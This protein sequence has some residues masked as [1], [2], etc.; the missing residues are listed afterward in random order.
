[1]PKSEA[2][3]RRSQSSVRRAV[4]EYTEQVKAAA[5]AGE[6]VLCW[7]CNQPISFDV[8]D[9]YAGDH[10]EPDHVF[11]VATHPELAD[12]P[13]NLRPAHR[14]CNRARGTDMEAT[15][16]GWT[17]IDWEA[18]GNDEQQPVRASTPRREVDEWST[19][20]ELDPAEVER[21]QLLDGGW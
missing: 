10:F 4:A 6:Q 19:T 17:S 21:Q 15:H 8:L 1:M 16:L 5:A 3:K 12:D 20:E 11:P 14:E 7:L 2:G 18:L 9:Q 13:N